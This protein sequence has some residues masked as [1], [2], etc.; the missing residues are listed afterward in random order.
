MNRKN[1]IFG[2][3]GLLGLLLLTQC[4]EKEPE[5]TAPVALFTAGS[6]TGTIE[7]LFT[8]DA[9]AS[10]DLEDSASLLRIRWDWEDDG[11]W[12]TD[13]ST[14]KIVKKGFNPK[15]IYK[16]SLEVIDTEGL[17]S[18]YSEIINIEDY[19]LIDPRDQK[20]YKT[21]RIGTQLWMAE[22][23]NFDI[24][25]GSYCLDDD[26]DNC[27]IYGRLYDWDAANFCCPFGWQLPTDD[28]WDLLTDYLGEEAG[29]KIKSNH[30]WR[31]GENGD[32]SSGFDALPASY[33][34]E[35]G[36]YM[37]LGGYAFFWTATENQENMAWSRLLSY[38]RII[39]ERN[40]YNK[41]NAF[42]VRCIKK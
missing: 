38:N 36:E 31:A 10:Y 32:N 19:F 22:N 15:G 42:S 2:L 23:M 13:Y 5:N 7:T 16:V 41:K 26:T 27:Q 12:D 34:T 28:D 18:K 6:N 37:A 35:Y 1:I 24:E 9:S 39:L 29:Y 3:S 33:L 4:T 21:V 40:F 14:D 30:G 20:Q 11:F 17:S 25:G 8:L